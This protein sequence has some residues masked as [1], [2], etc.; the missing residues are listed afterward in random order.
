MQESS[1]PKNTLPD[2]RTTKEFT[3]YFIPRLFDPSRFSEDGCRSGSAREF[4]SI[5][6]R[7]IEQFTS[8]QLT[9]I[10][11][12][13]WLGEA[14][15]GS[16]RA[17]GELLFSI[18][19]TMNRRDMFYDDWNDHHNSFID[20][21]RGLYRSTQPPT[22]ITPEIEERIKQCAEDCLKRPV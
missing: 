2:L 22:T 7:V 20:T 3:E 4:P 11:T 19:D 13:C 1:D 15:D 14:Q 5:L 6:S 21:I 12:E 17:L 9:K 16:R 8:E 10:V 18:L